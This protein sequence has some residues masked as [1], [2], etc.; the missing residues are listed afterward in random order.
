M[1][2]K[3]TLYALGKVSKTYGIRGQFKFKPF[4]EYKRRLLTLNQ[5][6]IGPNEEEV[7]LYTIQDIRFFR[8][9]IIF[10]LREIYNREQAKTIS[11]QYLFIDEDDTVKPPSGHYYI[12]DIVGC[13]VKFGRKTLGTIIDV[14]RKPEN[15]AQDIWVIEGNPEI[16]IPV[17]DQYIKK[18]DLKKKKIVVQDVEGFLPDN[19]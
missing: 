5:V 18:V 3:K 4:I 7:T 13:S 10:K 1:K 19:K 2:K 16:W 8:E 9:G 12:H 6:Y 11:G 15:F 14:H 17:L